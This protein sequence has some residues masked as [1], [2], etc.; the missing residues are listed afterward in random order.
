MAEKPEERALDKILRIMF[1]CHRKPERSF[2]FRGKQ[3]PLCARCTGILVGYIIGI[4]LRIFWQ[5]LPLWAVFVFMLPMI[6]DGLLQNVKHIMSNNP[7]RFV[8]G[9]IFGTVLIHGICWLERGFFL[10]AAWIVHG[11]MVLFNIAPHV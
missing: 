7:R 6:V 4:A 5:R 2:F 9:L 10:L 11:A 8:T 3:F 1:W